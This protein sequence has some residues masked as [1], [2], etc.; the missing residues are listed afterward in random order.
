[1]IPAVPTATYR[2]QLTRAF[3]FDDAAAIVPYLKSLGVS[4]LYT[5]PI[6][7]A[8]PGST[9][10]YDVIEPTALNPELGG[11]AAFLLLSDMLLRAEL[12]LM[13]DFVPNHM[14]VDC[15]DNKWW[16]DVLENGRHGKHAASF[17][18]DWDAGGG[19][20][21][22]PVLGRPLEECLAAGEIHLGEEN[23]KPV[24]RYFEHRFPLSPEARPASVEGGKQLRELLARQHYRLDHWRVANHSVNYRRFF[25]INS[26]AAVRVEL[27]DVFDATHA[28][29]RRLL[30]DGRLQGIRIDHIDGLADP[31]KYCGDLQQLIQASA[32][33]ASL[34]I[35]VEKIL[36]EGEDLPPWAGV[37]GTTGYEW[38][39]V[40][41]RTLADPVGIAHMARHWHTIP[42]PPPAFADALR[43]AK[44]YALDRLF[45]GE[46]AALVRL[47]AGVAADRSCEFSADRLSPALRS[48]LIEC[49]A[50]RTYV[51]D[52]ASPEDRAR[53]ERT[54]ARAGQKG[55]Q[56]AKE[57]FAFL[58]E[59]LITPKGSDERRF[60]TKLQQL[61]GPLMAK[62]LEDMALYRDHRLLALNEVG[63][64][65]TLPPLDAAEFHTRMSA[66][67]QNR[68]DG[69]T[70]TATHDTKRGEDV[71]M[72][73]LSVAELAQDWI[74]QSASW[75]RQNAR[76]IENRDGRGMPS[77]HHEYMLYQAMIGGWPAVSA[78]ADFHKR[79]AAYAIKAAREGK[80]DTS[81]LDPDEPYEAELQV[82]I[83]KILRP[84]NAAFLDSFEAFAGRCAL[85]GALRSLSQVALKT[86]QPGV[87]DLYQG[88]ELWDLTF[89]DPDNRRPVDF[90][91]RAAALREAST[92]P[93]WNRLAEPWQD[94]RIKLALTV[95]L[96][97]IRA[98]HR[99][100]F[101]RGEYF[102][103]PA[104]S[105]DILAFG[106]SH[107]NERLIAIAVRNFRQP[108]AD[109]TRWPQP[110]DWRGAIELPSAN[111]FQ[112]LLHTS[113]TEIRTGRTPV[114]DLLGRLPV[115]VVKLS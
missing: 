29:V 95:Q 42:P 71:R 5:S 80:Q 31:A 53:I 86:M 74:V 91:R 89:V 46:F 16:W 60:V 103:V 32:P 37:A 99:E 65:P 79:L 23:G 82:F 90:T 113:T 49:D 33:N 56:A 114:A 67:Q 44:E 19:R 28:G 14:C 57:I 84:D 39:N 12:G 3:G 22:L 112:N 17:D 51:V 30:A 35:V 63:N 85:L 70:A 54:I 93:D 50:Y 40:I 81:W 76:Y 96:L 6:F 115:A 72:R 61:T 108:T 101:A 62:G 1:M 104:D 38:L 109:G 34:Y 66:R 77:A 111:R 26:L 58:Q 41:T 55:G 47:L 75:M 25:D 10:G 73:I 18:I 102:P 48:F 13:I 59:V 2:V 69:L 78:D 9:H 107:A 83:G 105:P 36:A 7:T 87:P 4:H 68:P 45:A 110:Q 15:A 88:T 27:P 92:S 8:R 24:I 64:E 98:D 106:R 43:G 97:R 21:I 52:T 100:L 94:G 11:E 20:V